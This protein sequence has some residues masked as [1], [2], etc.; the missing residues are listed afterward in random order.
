[1]N[2]GLIDLMLHFHFFYNKQHG[3]MRDN[4]PKSVISCE[5]STNLYQP[6]LLLLQI[7][8]LLVLM[9]EGTL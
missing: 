7:L 2:V 3:C 9:E 6:A 1:M 4:F 8:L 5:G